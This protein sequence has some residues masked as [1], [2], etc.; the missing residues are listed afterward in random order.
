MNE[1]DANKIQCRICKGWYVFLG[2]HVTKKHHISMRDY[3]LEF[4]YNLTEGLIP[5]HYKNRLAGL[6]TEKSLQNLIAQSANLSTTGNQ[7]PWSREHIENRT[8]KHSEE[9]KLKMSIAAKNRRKK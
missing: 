5:K 3:K 2:A 6:I 9:T 4:G 7:K 8:Y 1:R